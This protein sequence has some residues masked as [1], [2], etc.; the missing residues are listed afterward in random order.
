MPRR[1][2]FLAALCTTLAAAPVAAQEDTFTI[3][4]SGLKA[5]V[6]RI[7]ANSNGRSYAVTANAASAGLAGLFRSFSVTS[8]V[9]GTLTGGQ[10]RPTRYVSQSDGARA[11]RAAEMTFESGTPTVIQAAREPDPEAPRIDPA[12]LTDVVDPLSGLYGVLRDTSPDEACKLDLS[13]FDGHRVS[14]VTLSR[15]R[16]AEGGIL[17]DGLYQRVAGYPPKDLAQR[18]SFPFTV[19]YAANADVLQAQELTMDSLFGPA[20]MTRN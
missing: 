6:L 1:L 5:G 20:R 17:C 18:A 16:P 7:A 14:R 2:P 12:S 9:T 19:F 4:V 11:G 8:R 15:P 13:M 3:T 10:F